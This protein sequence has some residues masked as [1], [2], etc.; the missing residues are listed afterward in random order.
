MKMT[1][2][3]LHF[4]TEMHRGQK[5]KHTGE[6]YIAHPIELTKI[7]SCIPEYLDPNCAVMAVALLHDVVEDCEVSMTQIE[8]EFGNTVAFG[9]SLLTELVVPGE[10]RAA[11]KAM[12]LLTLANAPDWVQDIKCADIM[13]NAPSIMEHD[14]K[15]AKVFVSECRALLNAMTLANSSLRS[16]AYASLGCSM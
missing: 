7:L 8:T 1:L 3:A 12:Q 15:F 6:D 14:P 2:K 16:R 5:R 10:N 13:S 4:A 11:R 9:V